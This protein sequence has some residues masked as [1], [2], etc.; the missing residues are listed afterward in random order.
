MS[1]LSELESLDS[2]GLV[3][4]GSTGGAWLYMSSC[5]RSYIISLILARGLTT[6]SLDLSCGQ[7]TNMVGEAI[8]QLLF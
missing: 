8:D 5:P 6:R 4:I 3:A 1:S 7:R 2:R